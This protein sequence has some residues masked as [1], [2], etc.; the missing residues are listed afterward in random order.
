[1]FG[2]YGIGRNEIAYVETV[3]VSIAPHIVALNAVGFTKNNVF[4]QT[5]IHSINAPSI[6]RIDD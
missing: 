3:M 1:M 6:L 4:A 2:I 5:N